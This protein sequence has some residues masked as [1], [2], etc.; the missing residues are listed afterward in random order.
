MTE[1]PLECSPQN[2]RRMH[3]RESARIT[4]FYKETGIYYTKNV[5]LR[6][7]RMDRNDFTESLFR[8][9]IAE[10]RDDIKK[11]ES[12][13]NGSIAERLSEKVD[14]LEKIMAVSVMKSKGG[15]TDIPIMA[16]NNS[17]EVQ[18]EANAEIPER[19]ITDV[20]L[21]EYNGRNGKPAYVAIDGIVYDVTNNDLWSQ[22]LHFGNQSGRDLTVEY[23]ACHVGRPRLNKLPIVG[24]LVITKTDK[25]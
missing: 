5:F 18:E 20:E 6:R 9:V 8:K 2:I 23:G 4:S 11:M 22:G 3:I 19:I 7:L 14:V 12:K 10:I 24:K 21:A 15:E 25:K 1:K 17:R 16:E 13:R